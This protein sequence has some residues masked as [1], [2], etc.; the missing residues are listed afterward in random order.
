MNSLNIAKILPCVVLFSDGR[1]VSGVCALFLQATIIF[2]PLAVRWAHVSRE[3]SGIE[4][5]LN[6]L[7]EINRHDQ[8]PYR[9]AP[10]K[11]RQMA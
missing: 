9:F 10:K 6:E 4:Q 11:F 7:S 3:R 8:D 1:P 5:L 2:W